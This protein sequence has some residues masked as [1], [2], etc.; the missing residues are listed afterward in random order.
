[1]DE[2]HREEIYLKTEE[3][4]SALKKLIEPFTL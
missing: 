3:F 2:A 4:I 1:M